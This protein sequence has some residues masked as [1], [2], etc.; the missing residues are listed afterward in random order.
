MAHED[1]AFAVLAELGPV[2]FH[3]RVDVD[4]A[5]ARQHEQREATHRLRR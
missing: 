3:R 5:P 1:I 2:F 4:E